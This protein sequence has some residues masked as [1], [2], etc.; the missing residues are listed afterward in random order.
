MSPGDRG[1]EVRNLDRLRRP[2]LLFDERR[3]RRRRFSKNRERLNREPLLLQGLD[4]SRRPFDVLKHAD[5]KS[6]C[7][8]L[9]RHQLS[10]H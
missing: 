1:T 2:Q 3:E 9:C 7:I 5:G 4:A 6:S 8:D 10:F